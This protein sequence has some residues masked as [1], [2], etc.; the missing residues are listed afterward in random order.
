MQFKIA[1]V[2]ALA[3]SVSA[4]SNVTYTTEVVTALT[5]V[6]PEA[7]Q[8]TYNGQTYT[9][10][11]VRDLKRVGRANAI[12]RRDGLWPSQYSCR[13]EISYPPHLPCG[14]AS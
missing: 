14:I 1:S 8:L 7:T 12:A 11:E 10:T 3:A 4:F 2:L 5:T 6:C 13:V 9:I